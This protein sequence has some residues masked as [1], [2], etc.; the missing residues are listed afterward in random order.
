LP[1]GPRQAG[2]QARRL[3]AVHLSGLDYT[4]AGAAAAAAGLV[5][6]VAGG[7]TL[8]S[9][10][11]LVGLGVPAVPANV[12]NTVSLLPGYLAGS[13]AQR[14]DLRPQLK[15]AKGLAVVGGLG[16]LAGSILLVVI[17][18]KDFRL[19][20]PYL[21]VA[22]CLLLLSQD[23]LRTVIG[24]RRE[25]GEGTASLTG[26]A[27]PSEVSGPDELLQAALVFAASVYGGFFGAGLGIMLLA[28][29]GL[30]SSE[31][32]ASVNAMKQALSFVINLVAAVFFLFSGRVTWALVPVMA[33]A[34]LAG[35]LL[36]GRLVPLI[37]ERLLRRLVVLAGL[38]VAASFWA[39]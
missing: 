12:T 29:L 16:G 20:V 4:A 25:G 35:G 30:F 39:A 17:P 8:I 5:N 28:V 13:W 32:L 10:P 19:A 33:A 7:G 38:G 37:P 6:A 21:I 9:F 26:Q 3:T 23:R 15:R 34:S 2:G 18:S 11:T 1:P 36:G 14:A 31:P 22:S 24:Q 27:G